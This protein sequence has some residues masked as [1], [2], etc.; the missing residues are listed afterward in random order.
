[1][2]SSKYSSDPLESERLPNF[3]YEALSGPNAVRLV[4][5]RPGRYGNDDVDIELIETHLPEAG[6][7]GKWRADGRDCPSYEV[8]SW[9]WGL[10]TPDQILRINHYDSV[11]AF[12]I[13]P[14]LKSALIALRRTTKVRHLWIDAI[15][16]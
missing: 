15:C 11:S 6:E 10:Q 14:N 12:Y 1:M 16:T 9:C 13:S 3:A 7:S 8:L 4:K 5:L 2:P